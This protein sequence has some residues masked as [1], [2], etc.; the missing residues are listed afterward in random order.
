MDCH[1]PGFPVHHQLPEVIHTHVHQ[2]GD[3]IQPSHPLWS[4]SPSTFNL[5][6]HQS[7][8]QWVSSSHHVAK[9]L[10][11]QLQ[12][13]S[14][15]WIFRT[16]FLYYWLVGSPCSPRD[17]QESSP[18]PQFKSINSSALSLLHIPTLTSIRSIQFL[19]FIEPIFAWKIPLVSL[20]F[21]K[22]SLVFPILLFSSISLHWSLK[23]FLSL[24]AILWSPSFKWVYLS[25]SPLLFTSLLFTAICKASSDSDFAFLHFFFLVM[26]LIPVSCTMSRT[27]VHN[28]SGTLSIRSS[29][30]NLFLTSAI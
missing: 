10:E 4:L 18:T 22:R 29:P 13:Q 17:S 11:F 3:A 27:S 21:L 23:A 25:F 8:F 12:H 1:T 20:I 16:D 7:L 15:Q 28:S 6:Q 24:L 14:F 30:L 19:S 9:E 5:S 2:V 26:V